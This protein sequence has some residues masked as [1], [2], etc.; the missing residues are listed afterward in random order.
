MGCGGKR[1]LDIRKLRAQRWFVLMLVDLV[2]TEKVD[3]SVTNE[4]LN[5]RK[6]TILTNPSHEDEANSSLLVL[7]QSTLNTS[8]ACSCQA[9]IGKS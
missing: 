8:R 7:D 9:R 2:S 3:I 5:Q 4:T 6:L 1:E